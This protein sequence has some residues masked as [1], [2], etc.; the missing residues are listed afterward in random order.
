MVMENDYLTKGN[1]NVRKIL[2]ADFH[3]FRKPTNVV[4]SLWCDVCRTWTDNPEAH[5]HEDPLY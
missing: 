4:E 2:F 5:R 1:K 3:I